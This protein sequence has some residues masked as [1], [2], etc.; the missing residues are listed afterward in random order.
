M[1]KT[2]GVTGAGYMML[3]NMSNSFRSFTHVFWSGG[4]MDNNGNVIDVAK[5]RAVQVAN[6]LNGKTLE[7][8]RLGIYL[9]KIGAP[10]EA[11]TIA[12]QNFASQGPYYG[13]AHAVLYYP[14]MS[15][16][17]VWLTT[18]LPELARRFVEVII[19]G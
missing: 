19:G 11:W 7:M 10:S 8:T 5:T 2:V 12:S 1:Y 9:E 3:D 15:E 13:S 14:G 4:H 17:G 16:Y 6:S 18:E